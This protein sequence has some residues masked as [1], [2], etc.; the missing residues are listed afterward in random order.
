MTSL[1]DAVPCE[2][3]QGRSFSVGPSRVRVKVD[4]LLTGDRFAL[5]EW[6][7]P[8]GAPAPPKHVHLEGSETFYV[9]EGELQFPLADRV[10][11]ASAGT[12][13]HLPPGTVHTL[14]N[15]GSRP[16]RA[17]ELFSPGTLLGLIEDVGRLLTAGPPTDREALA[18]LFARHRSAL[19]APSA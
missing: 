11:R 17:L 9:L 10:K 1:V 2:P 19:A 5:I 3:G 16:A 8:P 15:A 6:T 7:I 13:L 4:S 12:C 14:A 18:E